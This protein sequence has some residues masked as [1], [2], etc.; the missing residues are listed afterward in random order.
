MF[1]N[2]KQL[3]PTMQKKISNFEL[4]TKFFMQIL[5]CWA[6]YFNPKRAAFLRKFN[7]YLK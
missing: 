7:P 5:D 6:E 1:Y 3:K 2:L 4:K